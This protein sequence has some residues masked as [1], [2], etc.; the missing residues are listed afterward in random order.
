MTTGVEDQL[1]VCP[2]TKLP[3]EALSLEEAE[4]A[5]AGGRRLRAR[6]GGQATPVGP[7]QVV[8]MREDRAC[9]Y[10]VVE[11]IPILLV[12]ER[13]VPANAGP[14]TVDLSD[15]KYAETYE[16]MDFY[17]TVAE[18]EE[19]GVEDS[20]EAQFLM[21]TAKL[22]ELQEGSFPEPRDVWIDATYE[23]VAQWDSYRHLSPLKGKRVLQIGGK[24]T[25]ALRFLLAGASDAWTMS[26][27]VGELRY[28]RA[29]AQRL[30]LGD[31]LHCVA[32]VA[33]EMP[34]ADG[35][36]DAIFAGSTIHHM[37]TDI[38]FAECA[39]VLTKGGKFAAIEPWRAPLYG[40][41][42]RLLG[43]REPVHCRPLTSARVRPLFE[44][45]DWAA[46]V[47]HGALTRYPLLALAKLGVPVRTRTA[48]RVSRVDDAISSLVPRVREAGSSTALLGTRGDGSTAPDGEEAL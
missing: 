3:L 15:P 34:F 31:R 8:L 42:T 43:K 26:P 14:F 35:T 38:A 45:F 11:G 4:S 13:L 36:I 44:A 48:W 40:I 10:P 24:G 47:H 17:N 1:L 6:E 27:M 19:A 7:T 30:G 37:V 20:A 39:R 25:H 29:V 9:A 18:R 41:G 46:V 12:P 21:R 33:E 32:S 23:A 16:E 22:G 5:M 2:E 28:A